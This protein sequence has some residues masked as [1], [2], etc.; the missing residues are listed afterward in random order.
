MLHADVVLDFILRIFS[1]IYH[2]REDLTTIKRCS[3]WFNSDFVTAGFA[4]FQSYD[5]PTINAHDLYSLS[6]CYTFK[7]IVTIR[8]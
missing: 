8:Y 5:R 1:C 3:Q 6:I 4:P 7:N 2:T